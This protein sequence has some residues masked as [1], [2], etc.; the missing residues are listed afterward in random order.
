MLSLA[1]PRPALAAGIVGG[2]FPE[3]CSE[4]ALTSALGGGG[5]VTFN[6]GANPV[7]IVLTSRASINGSLVVDGGGLVTLSGG[8]ANGLFDVGHGATLE[9][10]DI[11]LTA[12]SDASGRRR[13]DPQRRHAAP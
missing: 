13:R 2:G 1:R 10:R 4:A 3:S 11:S 6:C 8:G 7:T 5:I 9:L 12:G